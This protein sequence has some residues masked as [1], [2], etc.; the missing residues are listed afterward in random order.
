[1]KYFVSVI[2]LSA[3]VGLLITGPVFAES[4]PASAVAAT[5]SAGAQVNPQPVAVSEEPVPMLV[6]KRVHSTDE[7][8]I[9]DFNRPVT[10]NN[11]KGDFGIWHRFPDDTEQS[12]AIEFDKDDALEEQNAHSLRLTY[13]IDSPHPAFNGLWMMLHNVDSS[14]Y[15]AISIYIKGDKHKGYPDVL[16]LEIK[17]LQ[18]LSGYTIHGISGE[19]QKFTLPLRWF[20]KSKE[21]S[22]LEQLVI[23][24][25]YNV[26]R[27]RTGSILVDHITLSN[28]SF[29]VR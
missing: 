18:G 11:V 23:V 20:R 29:A 14:K 13:D 2:H 6:P 4:A 9:A 19:W 27:P 24:F 17:D 15:N 21:F 26:T 10:R 1:M 16:R 22:K 25:D 3:I 8:V 7:L 5:Q 12:V 28:E